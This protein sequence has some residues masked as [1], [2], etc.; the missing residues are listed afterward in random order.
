M[1]N[2]VLL[3]L[4]KFLLTQPLLFFSSLSSLWLS[5]EASLMIPKLKHTCFLSFYPPKTLVNVLQIFPSTLC[6]FLSTL[7]PFQ[8]LTFVLLVTSHAVLAICL[9]G[10]LFVVFLAAVTCF[11]YKKRRSQNQKRHGPDQPLAFHT[12]R[13]PTAVKSPAGATTHYLKKSPSPTGPSK[14]PPG[15]S[16]CL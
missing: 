16:I 11:C 10:I 15:V 1:G 3:D 6:L 13:R 12:H 14:T 7:Q 8:W 9:G 4:W 5:Q 2:L